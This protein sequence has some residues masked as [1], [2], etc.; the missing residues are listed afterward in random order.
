MGFVRQQRQKVS[1]GC[2]ELRSVLRQEVRWGQLTVLINSLNIVF[3]MLSVFKRCVK[4]IASKLLFV[5]TNMF[6]FPCLNVGKLMP[7][8]KA[9]YL[10]NFQKF[11][12]TWIPEVSD[13]RESPLSSC[14][15]VWDNSSD[16]SQIA[17][18]NRSFISSSQVIAW[19]KVVCSRSFINMTK[20][21]EA[22][23]LP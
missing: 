19:G 16:S 15:S 14:W 2:P 22:Q 13:A 1:A 20:K 8:S 7:M 21:H 12:W 23:S 4:S 5:L 17:R 3:M 18:S 9:L 11:R 6:T 10:G